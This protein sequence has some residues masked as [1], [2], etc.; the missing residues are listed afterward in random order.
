MQMRQLRVGLMVAAVDLHSVDDVFGHE[1]LG[2]IL[3]ELGLEAADT[4]TTL[5]G[6][7]MVRVQNFL[8]AK[9]NKKAAL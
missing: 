3:R 2:R 6:H 8:V 7:G 9:F 1:S 5:L 4:L